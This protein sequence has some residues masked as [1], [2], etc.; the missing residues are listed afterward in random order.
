VDAAAVAG[1]TASLSV[2]F[3]N[4]RPPTNLPT[5]EGRRMARP[6]VRL[7]DRP[8]AEKARFLLDHPTT[9]DAAWTTERRQTG[10][11]REAFIERLLGRPAPRA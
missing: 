11:T 7:H 9:P 10:E 1:E 2:A 3:E 8:K 5:T 4:H 6:T